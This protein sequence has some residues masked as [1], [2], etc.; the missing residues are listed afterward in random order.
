MSEPLRLHA[1][2]PPAS[3][4]WLRY[5]AA[6]AAVPAAFW[7]REEMQA[8]VGGSLPTYLT[9]YPVVIVVAMLGGLGP[10]LLATALAALLAA[11]WILPPVG[12]WT[13]HAPADQLSLV[14]FS[15]FGLLMAIMAKRY[16]QSLRKVAGYE[17]ELVRR[18]TEEKF[19]TF[20]HT[21]AVGAAE[22]GLDGRFLEVNERLCA[23][24]GYSREELLRM[25]PAELLHP[26]DP[27]QE[28]GRLA[29]Y[30]RGESPLYQAEKRYVRKDGQVV[31]VQVAAAMVC[32]G[33]GEPLYS[34]GVVQDITEGKLATEKLRETA[35]ELQVA[36]AE[37]DDSRR[38][39]I[40]LLEDAL[41]ARRQET[42]ATEALRASERLLR[43]LSDQLPGGAIY[44][45]VWD[46]DGRIRYTYLSAGIERLF[47]LP[48]KDILADPDGFQRFVV[49]ED[50]PRLGAATAQS[51]RELTPF[52]CEFRQHTIAG[53]IRW[54]HCRSMP[55]R[56]ED[57][58]I[59]WDGIVV[60]I[61]ERKR[62]EEALQQAHGEL[63]Q[64]MEERTRELREKEV[65]LKEIHHRV[66]NNLQ[67]ISSLVSLQ[68]NGSTDATV[69]EVLRDV[70]GRVR[71]MALVHEKLYQSASLARIDFA[72]YSQSLLASI[73]RTHGAL[74]IAVG[75]RLTLEPLPLPVDIAVPCGL[76]LNEL[77]GNALKHAFRGRTGGEVTVTLDRAGDR[78]GRL[79]VHDNGIGLPAGWAWRQADSLGLRLVR[80]LAEQVN[81]TAEMSRDH[82]TT[83]EMTFELPETGND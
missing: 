22:L 50:R 20:F 58:A 1:R 7:L 56:L 5:G 38:A 61:T 83:F 35:A 31:W 69:R 80:M 32:D 30:L 48:V 65:L 67:V 27:L 60:D 18:E 57:G 8:M 3:R 45:Q 13:V 29:A 64:Q 2:Q 34:T 43:A 52:D 55:R 73:W 81:A 62:A 9:F 33:S 79:R 66:K 19:R 24:T 26:D 21:A 49:E 74:E 77:A 37:L 44:Q 46:P 71:S 6:M 47:G 51:A 25:T 72:E 53:E 15:G 59:L 75:L 11:F 10:C 36:N 4:W 70:T 28:D 17:H 14:F 41:I 82:G 42:E 39:A 40:N 23:I 63:A 68:A 54:V 76:I 16:Q 12:Q 78:R